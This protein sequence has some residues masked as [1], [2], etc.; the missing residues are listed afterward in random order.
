M[1]FHETTDDVRLSKQAHCDCLLALLSKFR[2]TAFVCSGGVPSH[3]ALL[4]ASEHNRGVLGDTGRAGSP[5]Q[6][7][8]EFAARVQTQTGDRAAALR[9]LVSQFAHDKLRLRARCQGRADQGRIDPHRREDPAQPRR[10]LYLL[11][12]QREGRLRHGPRT[13]R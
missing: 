11:A 5:R 12:Q 9:V 8:L 1:L 6:A 7:G 13:R 10:Q 3:P 2:L 4:R